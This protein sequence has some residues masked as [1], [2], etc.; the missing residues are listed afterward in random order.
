MVE[1][2]R[3][4]VREIEDYKLIQYACYLKIKITIS[5]NCKRS[6]PIRLVVIMQG[7]IYDFKD[8]IER[9]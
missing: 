6:Q 8:L 3:G 4:S 7:K 2:G 5:E 9:I 1:L